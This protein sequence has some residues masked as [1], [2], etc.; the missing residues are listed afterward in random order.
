MIKGYA[1]VSTDGQ[2]ARNIAV[3]A[4]AEPVYSEKQSGTKTDRAALLAYAGLSRGERCG[5]GYEA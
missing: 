3:G 5:A 2:A 1:R 4:G